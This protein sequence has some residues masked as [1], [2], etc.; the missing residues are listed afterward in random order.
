[1]KNNNSSLKSKVSRNNFATK[2]LILLTFLITIFIFSFIYIRN[3]Y[4]NNKCENLIYSIDYNFTNS[5]DKELRL[6]EVENFSLLSQDNDELSKNTSTMI[7]QA[8]GFRDAKPHKK[9]SVVGTFKKD[10]SKVW[11]MTEI[12]LIPFDY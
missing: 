1:M 4:I 9:I 7:V 2:K 6:I 10:S 5:N 12:D 8:T 3:V 11:E